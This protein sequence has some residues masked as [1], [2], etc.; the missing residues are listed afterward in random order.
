MAC[1][2]SLCLPSLLMLFRELCR[3]NGI[4]AS[5]AVSYP[6]KLESTMDV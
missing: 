4:G 2:M 3:A 5:G 1:R 6:S